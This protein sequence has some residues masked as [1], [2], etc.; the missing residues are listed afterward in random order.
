MK[1]TPIALFSFSVSLITI[2]ITLAAENSD[3]C[4]IVMP[5]GEKVNLSGLC[6][7]PS[8]E[9]SII[10]QQNNNNNSNQRVVYGEQEPAEGIQQKPKST[11][12]AAKR[13]SKREVERKRIFQEYS[14]YQQYI[15]YYRENL[16]N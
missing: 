12:Q 2:P 3:E 16:G 1:V 14:Q 9:N 11:S 15:K 13:R 4:H 7:S 10:N 5:S 8:T 6:Q